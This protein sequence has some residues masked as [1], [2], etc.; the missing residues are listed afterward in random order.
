MSSAA[1]YP[2]DRVDPAALHAAFGQAFADYLIG[3]FAL[4]P[5]QWPQFLARQCVDLALSRVLMQGG[6]PLAFAFVA[7]RPV[8]RPRW[9]LATMG[10]VPAARGSGAAPRLLDD[11]IA[12]AA[13][14]GLAE[15]E[16]EVFAQNERALRLYRSRGFETLHELQ[17]YEAA[18]PGGA[19]AEPPAAIDRLDRAAAFA[20]IEREALPRLAEL[21]L[22]QTPAALAAGTAELLGWQLGSALL[23]FSRLDAD[24]L[25]IA[26]LID[27]RPAQNEARRL[28]RALRAAHPAQRIRVPQLQRLDTGGQALRDSGFQPL[29]LHQLLMRAPTGAMR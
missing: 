17:G 20:W 5:A 29:P 21:P 27:W 18:A 22:Q 25:A 28:L 10:V 13:A 15:V 7:P 19:A 2:A 1:L 23:L 24:S 6:Q 16:L 11:F 8:G 14:A 26:S 3:P 12:R 9:R 4:S